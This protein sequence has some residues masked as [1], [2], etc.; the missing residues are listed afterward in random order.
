VRD[1]NEHIYSA[2]GGVNWESPQAFGLW[3]WYP[4]DEMGGEF[5]RERSH[6]QQALTL[7]GFAHS[8][9]SGWVPAP[10]GHPAL[11][12]DPTN[13]HLIG[14]SA[15]G[16]SLSGDLTI[17]AW[18]WLDAN[19]SSKFVVA[20]RG[21]NAETEATNFTFAFY[22]RLVTGSI[23]PEGFHEN[24]GGTNNTVQAAS[25]AVSAGQWQH[26]VLRRDTTAKRYDFFLNGVKET[27]STYTTNPTGGGS[28]VLCLGADRNGELDYMDGWMR[29]VRFYDRV[30]ADE[31]CQLPFHEPGRLDL[32]SMPHRRSLKTGNTVSR[33]RDVEAI[34]DPGISDMAEKADR[35]ILPGFPL[36]S[37]P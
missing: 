14:S 9:T 31:L 2:G 29:D 5:A 12:F 22:L 17:M 32:W 23:R 35:S 3:A 8:L 28:A 15:S 16:M 21:F 36:I 13:D 1:T 19:P 7:T 37:V 25:L 33:D 26:V 6:R 4:L 27:G 34:S 10:D 11:K 18:V 20:S 30:L 24:A